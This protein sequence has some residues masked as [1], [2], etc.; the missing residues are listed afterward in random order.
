MAIT[1]GPE[2]S[3]V[4]AGAVRL[5][6]EKV[7]QTYDNGTKLTA[8]STEL[9]Y[10]YRVYMQ[11]RGTLSSPSNTLYGDGEAIYNYSKAF[12]FDTTG[13]SLTAW[14][15]SH[16][17]LI[18][19]HT[20]RFPLTYGKS[21]T[22]TGY[23]W[24]SGIAGSTATPRT[25]FFN[26]NVPARPYAAPAAPSGVGVTRSS[27]ARHVVNW[28]RN[29]PGSASAPYQNVVV[30]R[31]DDAS[32]VYKTIATVG[33]VSS[34]T[35]SGTSAGRY[36][37]Y[38]VASRN[39]GG[40]SSWAYSPYFYT[41]PKAPTGVK[42]TRQGADVLVSWT[43]STSPHQRSVLAYRSSETGW[44]YPGWT[45]TGSSYLIKAPDPSVVY[46][47]AVL[48]QS[49]G[50]GGET[51]SSPWEHSNEVQL[52]APPK[53]PSGLSPA[54][55]E[56]GLPVRITWAHNSADT[57]EQTAY[58]VQYRTQG[59]ASWTSTGKQTGATAAHTFEAG[60]LA[61]G[62]YEVQVRTWGAHASA[63]GWS[64]THLLTV[65]ERPSVTITSPEAGPFPGSQAVVRWEFYDPEGSAQ[66]DYVVTLYSADGDRLWSRQRASTWASVLVEP[67]LEDGL[68]YEVGVKA[69]DAAGLWSAEERVALAVDYAEPPTPKASAEWQVSTGA[70]VLSWSTPAAVA[71][72]PKAE[73]VTVERS[74][75]GGDWT[76]VASGLPPSGSVVDPAPATNV[77]TLY[78][79]S[80]VSALPSTAAGPLLPVLPD[81]AG[82]VYLNGGPGL[83]R[84]V[85]V[86]GGTVVDADF[87]RAM[88]FVH[89]ANTSGKPL[90]VVYD[91]TE[92]SFKVAARLA[93][94]VEGSATYAELRAFIRE[95]D[96][97]ILYRDPTGERV[98]GAV[99]GLRHTAKGNRRTASFT[100]TETDDDMT[101]V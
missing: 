29:S 35:D 79:V 31:W 58:E 80:A 78:R 7:S 2:V 25:A 15:S 81:A 44:Q 45:S 16:I 63:G 26:V 64:S 50:P 24:A 59:G 36:Y 32:N 12:A 3:N 39:T 21:V 57:S 5:G 97:P 71:P 62:A 65:S 19:T 53:A 14:H 77:V 4:H 55:A 91:D 84:M 56:A 87:D 66:T 61:A 40:S 9:R 22:E 70:V 1:W 85:R 17:R 68:T 8:A 33:N 46:T 101:E 95:V 48:A 28:S 6:W 52:L 83:T 67:K 75:D 13:T 18:D 11:S 76:V 30:Q 94:T 93:P 20:D 49:N 73:T 89:V 82:W 37:R 42:A 41:T 98:W 47:Y 72:A 74:T 60:V 99:H 51:L 43:R 92:Q 38:R 88:D 34:Y 10:T 90:A 27:D 86:K 69:R 96:P 54:V 100:V 23:W